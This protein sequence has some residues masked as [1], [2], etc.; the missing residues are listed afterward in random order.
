MTKTTEDEAIRAAV[1]GRSH[2]DWPDIE[3]S[4]V[5]E[6]QTQSLCGFSNTPSLWTG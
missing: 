3:Q 1:G 2:T 5:N 4:P 6:F